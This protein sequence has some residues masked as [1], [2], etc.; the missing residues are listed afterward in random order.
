MDN[1]EKRFDI[2]VF[3]NFGLSDFGHLC[4]VAKLKLERCRGAG[5]L[6]HSNCEY[7]SVLY[8]RS[9]TESLAARSKTNA[10]VFY[11]TKLELWPVL[12]QPAAS[13]RKPLP[14]FYY[15]RKTV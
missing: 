3:G 2:T 14:L 15:E 13:E 12:L 6:G 10:A 9:I 4:F 5:Q 7:F 8:N 11:F 1:T